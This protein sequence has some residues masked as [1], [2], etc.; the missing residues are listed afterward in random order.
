MWWK[1]ADWG[2]LMMPP[3]YRR[4][5]CTCCFTCL[6]MAACVLTGICP[7]MLWRRTL[8]LMEEKIPNP[9]VSAYALM[10]AGGD[11]GASIAPQGLGIVVD[12]VAAS[13]WVLPIRQTMGISPEQIGMKIGRFLAALF[14][15]MGVG[16]LLYMKKYFAKQTL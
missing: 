3:N 14:P 2:E 12:T 1:L 15:L 16:G 5:K 13:Q 11:F 6:A 10:A 9:G 7:S 4:T 8:I